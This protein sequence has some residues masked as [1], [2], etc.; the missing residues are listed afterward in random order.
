MSQ[1][2]PANFLTST[3]SIVIKEQRGMKKR[4][5]GTAAERKNRSER[6]LGLLRGGALYSDICQLVNVSIPVVWRIAKG[7]GLLRHKRV[8][9][10]PDD[11]RRK[12]QR[13]LRG[14]DPAP[15]PQR[16]R[17]ITDAK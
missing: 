17:K 8:S 2:R 11:G 1:R 12:A 7:N 10:G 16:Q 6:I 9:V 14:R 4:N 13:I 3:P 15:P 5:Y